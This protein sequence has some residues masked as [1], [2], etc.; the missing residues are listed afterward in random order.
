MVEFWAL[1]CKKVNKKQLAHKFWAE[2]KW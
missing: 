2:I 1:K